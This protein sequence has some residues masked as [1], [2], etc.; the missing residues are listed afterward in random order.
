M[1]IAGVKMMQIYSADLLWFR[2][3]KHLMV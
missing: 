3:L 1:L 2:M